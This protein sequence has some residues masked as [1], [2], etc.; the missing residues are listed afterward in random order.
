MPTIEVKAYA[1]LNLTLDVLSRR[2]DGYHDL[3]MVMQSV[4]LSDAL[5]VS[6]GTGRGLAVSTDKSFL[7]C[8]ERNLAAAAALRF[9]E[10]TGTD[11]GGVSIEIEKRIPVCAGMA[12]GSSDAAAVLRAL[13]ELAG[14]GLDAAALAEIGAAV[15][16]DVPYCVH[17][18]TALA[19]G[20]GEVITPLAPLPPCHVVLCKPY[21]SISTPELFR[22]LDGVKLRRRPDTP[23]IVSALEAGDLEGVAR[24]L[25]NVF[26]DVFPPRRAAEITAIKNTL[27]QHGALGACMTG[28]G[29]TV[30]GIFPDGPSARRAHDDLSQT[31]R[32]TF[33]TKSI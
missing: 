8:D 24:R 32:E 10:T 11:L 13:D 31:Y 7:P 25:Y 21:F 22:Q 23:G 33:L 26:E 6:T 19:E 20:R 30:F 15:G 28:T 18:G 5:R 2:G 4:A 3:R 9:Q 29:S 16:S 27:I 17:G 14:T 1:K 12:G